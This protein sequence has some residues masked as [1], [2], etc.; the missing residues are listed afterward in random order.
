[1]TAAFGGTLTS[2]GQRKLLLIT[3]SLLYEFFSSIFMALG[4]TRSLF[5]KQGKQKF[6]QLES[7]LVLVTIFFLFSNVG[8]STSRGEAGEGAA[9]EGT[10]L[11]LDFS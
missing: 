8:A 2:V 9:I 4:S 5:I 11:I 7:T 3:H 1:M 6:L 10:F